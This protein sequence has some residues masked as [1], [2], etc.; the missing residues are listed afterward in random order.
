MRTIITLKPGANGV[1]RRTT[2]HFVI[3]KRYAGGYELY[4]GAGTDGG[5]WLAKGPNGMRERFKSRPEAEE[6]IEV[7]L[8]FMGYDRAY[9]GRDAEPF[10]QP[11]SELTTAE[12]NA[13]LRKIDAGKGPG[14]NRGIKLMSELSR[15]QG[16]GP[17]DAEV[18]GKWSET[19]GPDG[20]KHRVW[21]P[22]KKT[23]SEAAGSKD[24]EASEI[25]RDVQE[26]MERGFDIEGLKK[27]THGIKEG[28]V[29]YAYSRSQKNPVGVEV[30]YFKPLGGA[31]P[32]EAQYRQKDAMVD[33]YQKAGKWYYDIPN[34]SVP[35]GPFESRVLAER[36]IELQG[37]RARDSQRRRIVVHNH[38]PIRRAKD[39]DF[40]VDKLRKHGRD[41]VQRITESSTLRQLIQSEGYTRA[42]EAF[43]V[44]G[45]KYGRMLAG[46]SENV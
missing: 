10:T 19:Y 6:A 17:R 34:D 44:E 12:I 7:Q 39:A 31:K 27:G 3:A 18:E 16:S 24:A 1:V 9:K 28:G 15:R 22:S 21:V 13:E 33:V 5:A 41:L 46:L 35:E 25:R 30:L 40:S 11:P 2:D 4:E 8:D 14:G 38:L 43:I 26:L 36:H 23:A 29:T 37:H 20:K 45:W 32:R 42:E